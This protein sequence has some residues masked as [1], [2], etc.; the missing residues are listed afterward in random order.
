LG[1]R[2]V[3]GLEGL[4]RRREGVLKPR[5]LEGVAALRGL[6]QAEGEVTFAGL[7][8]RSCMSDAEY[9]EGLGLAPN[10]AL[11]GVDRMDWREEGLEG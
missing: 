8:R 1:E 7:H 9:L 10:K 6:R 3:C 5:F 11:V 4:R 2:G